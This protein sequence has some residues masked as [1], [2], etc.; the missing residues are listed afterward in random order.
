M[1]V[2]YAWEAYLMD[3]SQIV[4]WYAVALTEEDERWLGIKVG[5]ASSQQV[6]QIS[7]FVGRPACLETPLAVRK[8]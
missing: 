5:D 4:S 7:Q 1:H 8:N 6:A 2:W 3:E